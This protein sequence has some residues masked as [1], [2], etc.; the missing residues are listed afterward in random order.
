MNEEQI[1]D[2]IEGLSN[3]GFDGH[4]ISDILDLVEDVLENGNE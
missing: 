3:L 1:A 2:L 4:D